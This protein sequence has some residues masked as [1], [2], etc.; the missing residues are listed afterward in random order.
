MEAYPDD[1]ATT[2]CETSL[3]LFEGMHENIDGLD[4]VEIGV[5]VPIEGLSRA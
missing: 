4:V 2:E 5:C 3:A 1:G